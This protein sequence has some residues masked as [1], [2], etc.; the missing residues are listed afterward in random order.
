MAK[1]EIVVRPERRPC[2]VH[3]KKGLF[4]TW[5][6]RNGRTY[7]IVE[8]ENGHVDFV[9]PTKVQ[10]ADDNFDLRAWEEPNV[11]LVPDAWI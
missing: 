2:W 8:W 1:G 11:R 3:K 6:E 9:T 5:A 7:A 10:F 4:H